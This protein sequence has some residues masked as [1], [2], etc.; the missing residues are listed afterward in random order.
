M[1]FCINFGLP[2]H[3]YNLKVAAIVIYTDTFSES[4]FESFTF[5]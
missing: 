3:L 4:Q 1:Q 2:A 5:I